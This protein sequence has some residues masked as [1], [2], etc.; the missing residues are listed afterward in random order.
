[1]YSRVTETKQWS[2]NILPDV[3]DVRLLF[4]HS[5]CWVTL[6]CGWEQVS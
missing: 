6:L 2:S 5:V 3:K 4:K 1:M